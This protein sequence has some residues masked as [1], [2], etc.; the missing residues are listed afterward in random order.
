MHPDW[1]S[2][3]RQVWFNRLWVCL[4][5]IVVLAINIIVVFVIAG[6][7]GLRV[8]AGT[9]AVLITCLAVIVVTLAVL[10]RLARRDP[11]YEFRCPRCGER[12]FVPT[13]P[14]LV[15]RFFFYPG[16]AGMHLYALFARRCWHCGLPKWADPGELSSPT[17]GSA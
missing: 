14:P 3:R 4:I 7:F 8:S 13:L 15:Q 9:L 6:L 2:F 12:Y 1:K 5:S 17:A 16:S 11:V 10:V